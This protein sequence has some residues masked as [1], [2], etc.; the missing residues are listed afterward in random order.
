M[1]SGFTVDPPWRD[2]KEAHLVS[3]NDS[4][5]KDEKEEGEVLEFYKVGPT[6][7]IVDLIMDVMGQDEC[8]DSTIV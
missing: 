4:V 8:G 2:T 1:V 5:L 3:V 6:F 7:C